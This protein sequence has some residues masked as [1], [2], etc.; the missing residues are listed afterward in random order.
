MKELNFWF[1]W[2]IFKRCWKIVVLSAIIVG[3]CAYLTNKFLIKPVYQAQVSLYLGSVKSS[4]E[5][6]EDSQRGTAELIQTL[7]IGIQLANDF[8]EL[9]NSNRIKQFVAKRMA[10]VPEYSTAN[11][12]VSA[13]LI[14]QSRLI[15]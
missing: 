4:N 10:N 13:N 14:K 2:S 1:F 8:R 11:F 9:L 15:N 12:T 7:N 3:A 5:Q 6:S